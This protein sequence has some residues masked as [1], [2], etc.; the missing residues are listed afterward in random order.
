MISFMAVLNGNK[1]AIG[2]ALRRAAAAAT[3]P[4]DWA[5]ACACRGGRRWRYAN[6]ESGTG[7]PKSRAARQEM[8]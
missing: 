8:E 1:H 5:A 6:R 4:P 7:L 3:V 2:E